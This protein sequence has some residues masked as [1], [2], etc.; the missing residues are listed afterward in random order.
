[1]TRPRCAT[2]GC[3]LAVYAKGKCRAH[4]YRDWH[5]AYMRRRKAEATPAPATDAPAPPPLER[6]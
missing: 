1:M 3:R 5:R 2:P 4:W 6:T